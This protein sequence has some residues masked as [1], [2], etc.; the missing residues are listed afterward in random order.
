MAC[1]SSPFDIVTSSV[2]TTGYNSGT[3]YDPASPSLASFLQYL[4]EDVRAEALGVRKLHQNTTHRI[5]GFIAP[6]PK[7][8]PGLEDFKA[9][10]AHP[11][12][13]AVK[14]THRHLLSEQPPK[15]MLICSHPSTYVTLSAVA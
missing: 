3:F 7:P 1:C 15:V 8:I 4:P 14:L 11:P 12:Q 13:T 2:F 9:A 6:G 5:P 10:I